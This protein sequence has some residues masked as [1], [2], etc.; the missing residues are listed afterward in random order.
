ML[1]VS[2]SHI[3]PFLTH[4]IILVF[5]LF[6]R[7][8]H[9]LF[10]SCPLRFPLSILSSSQSLVS[11]LLQHHH[12]WQEE[13]AG[14]MKKRNH[15]SLRKEISL[16]SSDAFLPPSQHPIMSCRRRGRQASHSFRCNAKEETLRQGE[17]EHGLMVHHREMELEAGV[18]LMMVL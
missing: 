15:W 13:L 7:L 9:H 6:F 4:I 18:T 16:S 5:F 11:L 8:H 17:V 1:S 10:H 12:H 2:Y 3:C 14:H